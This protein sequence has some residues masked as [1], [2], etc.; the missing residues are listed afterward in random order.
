MDP[1]DDGYSIHAS[2][3]DYERTGQIRNAEILPEGTV[4]ALDPTIIS[5][6]LLSVYL[7]SKDIVVQFY[8]HCS[9]ASALTQGVKI[10]RLN[11]LQSEDDGI[12]PRETQNICSCTDP[13]FEPVPGE[14][15]N[16]YP[17][18]LH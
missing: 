18:L 12:P 10:A 2:T 17:S 8:R 1:A 11:H 14:S 7:S 6:D 16:S 3:K 9:A 4:T 5:T 15:S 13:N